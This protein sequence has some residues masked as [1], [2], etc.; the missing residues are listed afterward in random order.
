[1]AKLQDL[2]YDAR[3]MVEN[4]ARERTAKR[5]RPIICVG[6]ND[7]CSDCM[8]ERLYRVTVAE[9]ETADAVLVRFAIY[10]R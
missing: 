2:Y 9:R 8:V 5:T 1:M 6:C 10:G 7:D 4:R 3:L